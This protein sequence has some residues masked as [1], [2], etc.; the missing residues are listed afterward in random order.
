MYK[1]QTMLKLLFIIA[2]IVTIMLFTNLKNTNNY[3]EL[4]EE[5]IA[6]VVANENITM[7]HA[8]TLFKENKPVTVISYT[9]DDKTG[10]ITAYNDNGTIH[11]NK[12]LSTHVNI[13]KK[14]EVLGV[15]TGLPFIT[16]TFYD[17]TLLQ[18]TKKIS[19]Y[20]DDIK[21]DIK[22][23]E[24]LRSLIIPLHGKSEAVQTNPIIIEFYDDN[25]SII[26]TYPADSILEEY[27]V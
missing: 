22:T 14:V 19:I 6:S 16:L 12:T 1:K 3:I 24:Q 2:I 25:D 4:T 11:H 20:Y 26:F 18:N 10:F 5:Q 13:N 8:E 21:K 9:K 23:D 15:A 27:A 7:L 17:T